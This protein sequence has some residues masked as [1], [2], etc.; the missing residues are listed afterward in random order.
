MSVEKE[1]ILTEVGGRTPGFVDDD[2]RFLKTM[3][4][5]Q[6][7]ASLETHVSS[8]PS[9]C[10]GWVRDGIVNVLVCDLRMPGLDGLS[11]LER[12]RKVSSEA[13]LVLLTS[14]EPTSDERRRL[15]AIRAR[16][17]DKTSG[18]PEFLD[19]LLRGEPRKEAHHLAHLE[20]RLARLEKLHREWVADLLAQLEEIPEREEAWISSSEEA[21]T[22][23]ELIHDIRSA[24]PRGVEHIRLW[25]QALES[26]RQ[27]GRE[28]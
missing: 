20:A 23:A 18:L 14:F 13:E 24:S 25:R 21:F 22:V 12:A 8:D 15:A 9:D 28:A 11:V 10:I 4:M 27:M 19:G 2:Q 16:V 7:E 26:L 6:A 5:W 17:V 3:A 1:A